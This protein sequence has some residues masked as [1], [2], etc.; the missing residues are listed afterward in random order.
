MFSFQSKQSPAQ[1]VGLLKAYSSLSGAQLWVDF[2]TC[3]DEASDSS[4]VRLLKAFK[5]EKPS[6]T[7]SKA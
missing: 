6:K 2:C 3:Q 7:L 1:P 4:E 5:N